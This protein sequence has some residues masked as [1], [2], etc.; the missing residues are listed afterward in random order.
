MKRK[1]LTALL[2]SVGILLLV[3]GCNIEDK[4][5]KSNIELPKYSEI[6]AI[7]HK[8]EKTAVYKIENDGIY[9]IGTMD[10]VI[11]M[12]YNL[13]GVAYAYNIRV[14]Q[15]K[16]LNNTKITINKEGKEK[17]INN[18]FNFNDIKLNFDGNFL[19][20]RCFEKDS[21]ESAEGLN[22]INIKSFK[23]VKLNSKVFVS[24]SLYR[25]QDK[26]NLLYYGSIQG[27]KDSA[28]IYAYNMD[29]GKEQV[30]LD[31]IQGYCTFFQPF[32]EDLLFLD[33]DG[34]YYYNKSENKNIKLKTN[35]KD[36]YYTVYNK[37]SDEIYLTAKEEYEKLPAIYKIDK[38]RTKVEKLTYDFPKMV[39]LDTGMTIDS[40]G[41]VYF[42]GEMSLEDSKKKDIF[43][44]NKSD[45]SINL[46]STHTGDYSIYGRTDK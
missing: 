45:K 28:N 30:Y 33:R 1:G 2:I 11:E 22:V 7:E 31:K 46:I 5:I 10:D 23:K 44:I 18:C 42:V 41:N 27:E 38:T 15:G 12:A 17:T 32:K 4:T 13:K 19:A 25:W 24:G 9:K 39:N 37:E 21:L 26:G 3:V 6:T 14:A 34:M 40:K 35:I 16:N 20:Y 43:M 8:E 36:V 29:S